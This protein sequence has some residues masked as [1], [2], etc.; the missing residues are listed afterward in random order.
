MR[1]DIGAVLAGLGAFLIVIALALPFFIAGQVLKFPL[2]YYYTATL[3]SPNTT[4]FS[5]SKFSEVTGANVHGIYTLKGDAKA[6]NSSTAVWDLF[7]YLYNVGTGEQ[8]E[9]QS[10]TVAFDRKTAAL[11]D[12]CGQNLNGKPVHVGGIAGFVFPIGTKQQTYQVFDTTLLRPEPF[13][14]SGTSNVNGISTYKFVENVAPTNI[15]FTPLSATQPEYYAIN[16]TYWID[17]DTGALLKILEHQQQYLVDPTTGAKT[18]VLF[19]GTLAPTPASVA[20]IVAIDNSGRLKITL[21]EVVIPLVAGILGVVLLVWGILL[22][23]RGRQ[24]V[25]E[26]GPDDATTREIPVTAPDGDA[27]ASPPADRPATGGG[28]HAA[29]SAQPAGIVPGL[30]GDPAQAAADRP[31]GE[32]PE[33]GA[34]PTTG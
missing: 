10:R 29:G 17:P 31:G 26:P 24:D 27:A 18:L 30:D 15:G 5:P 8:I 19:D 1:R 33:A 34:E 6:G 16:L 4:Y 25:A 3:V 22:F 23:R 21:I 11:V 2:N 13:T 28:R 12:C 20:A 9:I 32:D 7:T 14:Y